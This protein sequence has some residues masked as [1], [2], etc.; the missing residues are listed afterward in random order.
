M[1]F[2][3]G[4]SG[5]GVYGHILTYLELAVAILLASHILLKKQDPNV[6]LGWLLATALS[7]LVAGIFYLGIGINPFEKYT[8]KKIRSRAETRASDASRRS[9][10]FLEENTSKM[11]SLG[12][13]NFYGTLNWISQFRGEAIES[14]NSLELL[15]NSDVVYRRLEDSILGAKKYILVQFYQIQADPVGLGFLDLL[16]QQAQRGIDVYVLYDALGSI[17]LKDT[18]VQG[19][20]KSG[21]KINHFLEISPI[22]RRFQVN[23][24]NHRKLVVIDGEEAFVGGF[25]IGQ[26]YLQGPNLDDPRWIDLIYRIKGSAIADL[27]S[28]FYE[29]WHFTTGVSL[30]ETLFASSSK[31]PNSTS[32][33]SVLPSGPSDS[34][35]PFHTTL[36]NILFEAKS[37]V[38]IMTPYF[39]PDRSLLNAMRI[40]VGRGV[41]VRIIVPLR[42]NHPLTDICASSYFSEIYAYGIDLIRLKNG[43]CHGKI[44]LADDDVIL[45][46]SSNMDYRSF[47][48][49]FE[50]DLFIRDK[51]LG[52]KLLDFLTELSLKSTPLSLKDISSHP[53]SRL[54]LRR[55]M[56]LIAPLM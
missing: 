15:I 49:N 39:V 16:K 1:G 53:P 7:P 17:S 20:R 43:V 4:I 12:F 21:V 42:S 38:W 5:H 36:L 23:W 26:T 13:K 3:F 51:T 46:G 56:R 25:N 6:C 27:L 30:R 50:T 45:S 22:K 8:R 24:R 11:N 2:F 37:Y 44:V 52:A 41:H 14:D 54:I 35:S 48:L 19:Y 47:F 29:D 18:M 31:V 10:E 55:V 40:A 32:L 9:T 34:S 28:H 33:V